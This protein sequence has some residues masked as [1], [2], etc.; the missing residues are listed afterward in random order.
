MLKKC[1]YTTVRI[2]TKRGR[3]LYFNLNFVFIPRKCNKRAI[4]VFNVKGHFHFKS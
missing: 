3:L 2:R 4:Y 1:Y